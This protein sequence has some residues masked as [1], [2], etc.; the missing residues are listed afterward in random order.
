MQWEL[1]AH[2]LILKMPLTLLTTKLLFKMFEIRLQGA[3]PRPTEILSQYWS[4]IY[5]N[6]G[7]ISTIQNIR[8]FDTQCS[9]LGH[10]L[11]VIDINGID[12]AT[13]RT[14]IVL[15]ANDTVI[16]TKEGAKNKSVEYRNRLIGLQCNLK[17]SPHIEGW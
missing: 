2:S 11:T 16:Y 3:C 8:F 4:A 15:Y 5:S 13:T 17:N 7:E 10:L 6:W 1:H 9:I 12:F 14:V